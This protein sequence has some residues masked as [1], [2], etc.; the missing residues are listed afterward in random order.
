MGEFTD[1]LNDRHTISAET[2]LINLLLELF[3]P[4]SSLSYHSYFIAVQTRYSLLSVCFRLRF[5]Y[6]FS[7]Y[8]IYVA[9]NSDTDFPSAF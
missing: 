4:S 9:K 7:C 3:V 5:D 6:N 1:S 8:E 2:V